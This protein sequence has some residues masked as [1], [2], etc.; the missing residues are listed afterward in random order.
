MSHSL[1]RRQILASLVVLPFIPSA[2]L[3]AGPNSVKQEFANYKRQQN[4]EFLL[5]SE[6][7]ERYQSDYLHQF[8]QYE[9]QVSK[10]WRAPEFSD[11]INWVQYS[12]DYKRKSVVDYQLD[13]IRLD[14]L[15]ANDLDKEQLA[16]QVKKDL[17][18][19]LSAS[20][21][22]STVRDPVLRKIDR[23][24]ISPDRNG[25]HQRV[26]AELT[27][28]YGS[29]DQAVEKLASQALDLKQNEKGQQILQ[30]K[31]PL[32][33]K[34]PIKRAEKYQAAVTQFGKKWSV[35]PALILA[36]M[37]TES[38]FNPMARSHVPAF[39]L[40]QIVPAS[41]GRDAS[42]AMYGKSRLLS[43]SELY[44]P[45]T[46]IE[47][48]AAYINMLQT[49]YLRKIKDP[50]SLLYCSIAAYNTGTGNVAKAFTGNSSSITRASSLINSFTSDQVFQFLMQGLP[51]AE[52]RSYLAKVNKKLLHYREI[53]A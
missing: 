22:G 39:G 37:H 48:G 4:S 26:L 16:A 31:I 6:E 5:L 51:Y 14:Y 17:K 44:N 10:Y 29:L 52:T 50:V 45:E 2:Q 15:E 47:V 19:L 20:Y 40:M 1:K 8:T 36:I 13:Q 24:E 30:V 38:H 43:A 21:Q 34:L 46:N 28:E 35:D 11:S 23:L 25:N 7:F 53:L 3:F 41:A 32:S 33:K 12:N 49:K 18:A 9:Q 42:K 27:V